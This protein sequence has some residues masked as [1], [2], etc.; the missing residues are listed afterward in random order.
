MKILKFIFGMVILLACNE[1]AKIPEVPEIELTYDFE[2]DM[3]GWIGGFSDLP[4][5]N[6][7]IYEL[8]VTHIQLPEDTGSEEFAIGIQGHNRSD[9]LFMFIKKEI[10]GLKPSQSYN[11]KFVVELA[12]QYP[13][14]SV[15]IGGSPG[16]SV[17]LKA[18]ATT[19]EPKPVVDDSGMEEYLIM[20]LDKGNQSQDGSDMF[21]LGTIGIEGEEFKYELI[22]RSNKDRP[23]PITSGENG[24]IWLIIGTDSGFEGL[25]VLYYNTI[26]VTLKEI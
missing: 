5:Q 2:E 6:Q 26:R 7:E 22:T 24:N 10:T 12:S 20:N 18:G 8:A 23:F 17:Y 16:G 25:T 19:F 11:I 3:Q 21:N 14:E 1:E 4:Y 9:D 13:E 15:G